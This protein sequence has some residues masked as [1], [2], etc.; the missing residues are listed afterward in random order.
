MPESFALDDIRRRDRAQYKADRATHPALVFRLMLDA[1]VWSLLIPIIARRPDL[2]KLLSRTGPGRRQVYRGLAAETIWRCCHRI[3]KRPVLMK[4]RPCL[5]EGLLVYRFL[6]MSGYEPTLHF[7][8]DKASLDSDRV[9]AH[10]WIKLGTRIFN[11]PEPLMVEIY[12]R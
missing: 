2:S 6:V 4:D 8:V 10:C 11:P 1:R 12:V 7:G 3:L 9:R 5:R